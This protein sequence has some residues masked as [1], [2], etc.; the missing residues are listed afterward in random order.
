MLEPMVGELEA[1]K[2]AEESEG[3]IVIKND[4]IDVPLMVRK[5][6]GGFG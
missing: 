3:A 4:G 1:R 2:I 6:D 5:S